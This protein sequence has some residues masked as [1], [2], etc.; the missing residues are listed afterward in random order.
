M[1]AAAHGCPC[2]KRKITESILLRGGEVNSR[3]DDERTPL[4]HAASAGHKA[5]VAI[6]LKHGARADLRQKAYGATPIHVAARLGRFEI[7][8]ILASHGAEVDVKNYRGQTPLH[9][10]ARM[11]YSDVAQLLLSRGAQPDSKDD[12]QRTPIHY[13]FEW[14]HS[15]LA[16]L[17][18]ESRVSMH[19][20]PT[21]RPLL[22]AE[23]PGLLEEQSKQTPEQILFLNIKFGNLAKVQALLEQGLNVNLQDDYGWTPL[24]LAA[25]EG[26]TEIAKLLLE[27]G[28]WL[29]A[30]DYDFVT[31]LYRAASAG[32]ASLVELF[33]DRGARI[34]NKRKGYEAT[35]LHVAAWRGNID[36][37]KIL[38][39]HEAD[40]QATNHAGETPLDLALREGQSAAADLLSRFM[41]KVQYTPSKPQ[42]P[43][44]TF[45]D[46]LKAAEIGNLKLFQ[47]CFDANTAEYD[48][49]TRRL[50]SSIVTNQADRKFDSERIEVID[51]H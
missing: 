1:D 16:K 23:F 24:H 51:E 9:L 36:T 8:E 20:A 7:V 25:R 3:D 43:H 48:S 5:P 38:L 37:I 30:M 14:N 47:K 39:R 27:H 10:A 18:T 29:D 4:Y 22:S 15:K 6:L 42:A 40:A 49:V 2:G 41:A 46:F 12:D 32:Y 13:A 28:A 45:R 21:S 34:E 11:G 33:I 50:S 17:L 35:P 31:P 44:L 19:P 26:K